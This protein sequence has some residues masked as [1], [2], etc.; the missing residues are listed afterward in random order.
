LEKIRNS[1]VGERDRKGAEEKISEGQNAAESRDALERI[2]PAE[3]E[4]I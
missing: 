1:F 2:G 3:L 4:K